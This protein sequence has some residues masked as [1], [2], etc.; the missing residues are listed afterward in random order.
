[1]AVRWWAGERL[2]LLLSGNIRAIPCAVVQRTSSLLSA[3]LRTA[4]RF[5]A[6]DRH[7][8]LVLG[9]QGSQGERNLWAHDK[10]DTLCVLL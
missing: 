9:L 10:S 5:M 6:F 1:M 8:N 4:C 7:M 3:C 2:L